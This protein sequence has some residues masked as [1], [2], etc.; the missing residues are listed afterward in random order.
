MADTTLNRLEELVQTA[1][2]LQ[3]S[4]ESADI[5]EETIIGAVGIDAKNA[6]DEKM[7]DVAITMDNLM[8][9]VFSK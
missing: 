6:L 4:L 5:T 3:V 9:E 8:Y 2:D 7:T 1:K